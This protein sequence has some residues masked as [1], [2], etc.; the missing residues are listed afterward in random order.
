MT[1]LSRN[2]TGSRCCC[3]RHTRNYRMRHAMDPGGQESHEAWPLCTVDCIVVVAPPLF[4]SLRKAA[5][6][7]P[8]RQRRQTMAPSPGVPQG[9]PTHTAPPA[10]QHP[11]PSAPQHRSNN[12]PTLTPTHTQPRLS[13]SSSRIATRLPLRFSSLPLSRDAYLF[14]PGLAGHD[15][16]VRACHRVCSD[17]SAELAGPQG[18]G[19][20]TAAGHSRQQRKPVLAGEIS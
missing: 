20:G 4:R 9:Q 1:P 15:R 8:R 3:C 11:R 16:A 17:V 18:Q 14:A 12:K 10:H 2:F 13:D 6:L 7:N 5:A 19:H